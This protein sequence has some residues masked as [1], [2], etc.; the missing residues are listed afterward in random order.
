MVRRRGIIV[1][2]ALLLVLPS[3]S[4][5]TG[6]Q[7]PVAIIEASPARG[8]APLTVKF[9]GALSFDPKGL[10]VRYEWDFGDGERA[11]GPKVSHVYERN[12]IY[13]ATLTVSDQ[14]GASDQDHVRI[15]VGNPP[16]QAIFTASPV[17][18]WPPLPVTFD[19]SVSFDPEGDAIVSYEW[20]F[21]DGKRASGLRVTHTYPQAGR[22]TVQLAITD[23]DG[24]M[25]TAT[26]VVNVLDFI[27]TRDLRVGKSPMS[28]VTVDFDGDGR[29]DI[30]VANSESDEVSLFF[31]AA[32]AGAFIRG[33]RI[34]VG[35]RPV[36]L[37]AADFDGNDRLDLAVAHLESGVVTLLLNDGGREFKKGQKWRVGRWA[38]AITSADFN[39]DGLSDLAVTDPDADQVIVLL[40][41]GTGG[42]EE[43]QSMPVGRWPAALASGDFNGDGRMDLAVANFQADSMTLLWG[44]GVGGFYE[45]GVR[46][47]GKGPVALTAVDL[48]RDDLLDLV[49]ANSRSG[50]LSIFLGMGDG[51]FRLDSEIPAGDDVRGVAVGDFDGD[52]SLD[53]ATANS[54]ADTVSVFL[55]DGVGGFDTPSQGREYPAD[56]SPAALATGDLD[57]DGFL[58]F[59]IV[60]FAGD[61]ISILLNK[62]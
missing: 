34:S 58:D 45:S 62:L 46:E 35:R 7:P 30:A 22:F 18:G 23:R 2:L 26:L 40:G 25:S 24:A 28:A 5:L 52:G 20:D 27:S 9:D 39:R 53:L 41:D 48:N 36:A 6:N 57:R 32:E 60:H 59:V 8:D 33:E 43:P 42:F 13:L 21:G 61:R 16:P 47:V 44:D 12:G 38:S 19:G 15:V 51:R 55:N 50:S 4:L 37:T 29:L 14:F 31:G 3:C 10:L 49:V 17:S 56:S 54:G 11:E 1:C